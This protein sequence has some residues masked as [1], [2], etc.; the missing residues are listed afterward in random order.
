MRVLV[1]GVSGAILGG[2]ET[3]LFNMNAHMS[4]NCIFD[5]VIRGNK[6]IHEDRIRQNGGRIFHITS[7]R[8]SRTKYISDT[9]RLL[10]EYKS[11]GNVVYFNLFSMCHVAPVLIAKL[12]GY[13][14]VLHTHNNN[15]ANKNKWYQLLHY[16]NQGLFKNM[17]CVRLANSPASARFMFGED[18]YSLMIYNAIDVAKYAFHPDIREAMR[19]S[20][21]VQNKIVY[22]F[23]GR[24]MSEKNLLF[25]MDIFQEVY[26]MQKDAVLLVVGEGNMRSEIEEKIYKLGLGSVVLLLGNRSDANALYQAMDVFMLPSLFEGLGIAL[27]EAQTS[28]L[29]CITSANVVPIEARITEGSFVFESLENDASIWAQQSIELSNKKENRELAYRVVENSRFS[30]HKEA[31]FLEQVFANLE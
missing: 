9:C 7:Y 20:L 10:E 19:S 6:C 31:K 14:I 24:L 25:L 30:I 28:G 27:I 3:F 18:I 4:G 29:P 17:K 23:V 13:K 22:G 26:N 12:K 21:G 2:I 16:I 5:Y 15:M 11:V 8:K 1:F